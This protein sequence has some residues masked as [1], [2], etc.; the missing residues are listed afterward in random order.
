MGGA[1]IEVTGK[2]PGEVLRRLDQ[3]RVE[4]RNLGLYEEENTPVRYDPEDKV[5]RT[6][7]KVHS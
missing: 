6:A 7:I 3:K 1:I 5:W 2:T 4:A